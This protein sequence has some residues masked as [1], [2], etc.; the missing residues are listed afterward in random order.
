M[1][2]DTFPGTQALQSPDTTVIRSDQE[3][4]DGNL[5]MDKGS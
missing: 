5:T 3:K 1:H 4:D 2:T